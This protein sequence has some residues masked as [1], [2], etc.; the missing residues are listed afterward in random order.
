MLKYKLYLLIFG[1]QILVPNI[2]SLKSINYS[3]LKEVNINVQLKF[4]G[5][6][7]LSLSVII[8]LMRAA[9]AV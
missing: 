5:E 9:L 3:T 7:E 4:T 2:K 1:V 6:H 8:V